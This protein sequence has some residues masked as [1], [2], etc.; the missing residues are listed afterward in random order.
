MKTS[1]ICIAI[2]RFFHT[3][4]A[5]FP[6]T[7]ISLSITFKNAITALCTD[8]YINI[9]RHAEDINDPLMRKMK[10]FTIKLTRVV[11]DDFE[12]LN[13]T[14]SADKKTTRSKSASPLQQA[15]RRRKQPT[16][17]T[18]E[19]SMSR[20]EETSSDESKPNATA[21]T[22]Q[23]AKRRDKQPAKT[24]VVSNKRS[25]RSNSSIDE[26]SFE[27][28]ERRAKRKKRNQPP[29]KLKTINS[30]S[31]DDMQ[32]MAGAKK[33]TNVTLR[34]RKNISS[35]TDEDDSNPRVHNE[36]VEL[37]HSDASESMPVTSKLIHSTMIH[38]NASL[39][40]INESDN[41]FT[42]FLSE[43]LSSPEPK[44]QNGSPESAILPDHELNTVTQN[45]MDQQME[46]TPRN[47]AKSK[48]KS[49]G[50]H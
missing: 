44:S 28:P 19:S 3:N 8:E 22:S 34:R 6:R 9:F 36:S 25:L 24:N 31:T 12:E 39:T 48:E 21:S 42:S 14:P 32:V 43:K 35:S 23:Q 2:D 46:E 11:V 37:T 40:H 50:I 17:K 7:D 4:N 41:E 38:G 18:V 27:T 45:T 47:A 49:R 30:E 16:K 15:N 26:I 1:N 33:K 20:L 10:S 29:K 5:N 13:K